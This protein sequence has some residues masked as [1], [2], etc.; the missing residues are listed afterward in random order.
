MKGSELQSAG[1]LFEPTTLR[2]RVLCSTDWAS[3][4]RYFGLRPSK[5]SSRYRLTSCCRFVENGECFWYKW[6][7]IHYKPTIQNVLFEGCS[8]G[9]TCLILVSQIFQLVIKNWIFIVSQQFKLILKKWILMTSQW[10]KEHDHR[11]RVYACLG[12]K[13]VTEARIANANQVWSK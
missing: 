11:A 6:R 9:M 13:A 8:H 12:V 4:A 10:Y 7:C 1:F 2:L 3:R 5:S